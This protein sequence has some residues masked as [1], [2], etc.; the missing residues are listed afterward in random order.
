VLPESPR[1]LISKGRYKE[2]E[3][4]IRKIAKVNKVK[5]PENIVGEDSVE[6]PIKVSVLKMFTIPKLLMRTLIIYFNW[7]VYM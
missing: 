1:W 3:T 4:I 2:A 5:I 6:K 7:Y